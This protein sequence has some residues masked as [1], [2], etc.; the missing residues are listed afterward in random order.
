MPGPPP[1]R[2]EERTS[3]HVPA[4]GHARKGDL[5]PVARIPNADPN[6]H[7]RAKSWYKSLRTSGMSAYYQDSD[8]ATAQMI[9]DYITLWYKR[10]RA[11]DMA[12]IMSLMAQL[13][14]TEGA[15]RGVLRVE[16]SEPEETAEDAQ[17][18]A[19]QEYKAIL[20]GGSGN[21]TP[22]PDFEDVIDVEIE[23]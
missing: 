13:G 23:E 21:A 11:M 4:N 16:L 15:R 19:I 8:W 18:A 1:K 20:A 12:N 6:W 5:M 9:G 7:K 10:P 3:R 2:S 17:I 14:T 22:A